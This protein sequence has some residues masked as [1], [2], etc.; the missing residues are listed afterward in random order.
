M[1]S[2][3]LCECRFFIPRTRDEEISDGEFHGV[4]SWQWLD[5]E[6]IGRFYGRTKSKEKLQGLW[7]SP[8][9]GALVRDESVQFTVAVPKGRLRE[10][11]RLL[12]TACVVF[13]QQCIYLSIAGIVEFVE[14]QKWPK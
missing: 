9:T 4:D 6:L 10:L 11:R 12:R 13:A 5:D 1:S 2:K 3:I 8:T 7:R 14:P